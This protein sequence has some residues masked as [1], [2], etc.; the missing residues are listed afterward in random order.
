MTAQ[1][2]WKRLLLTLTSLANIYL[3]CPDIHEN[4]LG[5]KQNYQDIVPDLKNTQ[6]S[7]LILLSGHNL[8][9]RALSEP[10]FPSVCGMIVVN[11]CRERNFKINNKPDK[12]RMIKIQE[13]MSC[14]STLLPSQKNVLAILVL[15]IC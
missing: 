5:T 7:K 1:F 12:C 4:V 11:I 2:T 14:F 13:E 10:E 3:K 8:Q 15:M 9:L 6:S